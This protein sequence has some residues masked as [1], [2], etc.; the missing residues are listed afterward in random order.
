MSEVADLVEICADRPALGVS[1]QQWSSRSV[2]DVVVQIGTT[3]S[4]TV[5]WP[6]L[7]ESE[8]EELPQQKKLLEIC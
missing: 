8:F 2:H 5:R 7:S 3:Q 1:D 6:V 4:V